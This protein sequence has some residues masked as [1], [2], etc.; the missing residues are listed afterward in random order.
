MFTEPPRLALTNSASTHNCPPEP[1]FTKPENIWQAR[2]EEMATIVVAEA[3]ERPK[4]LSYI[5]CHRE[6]R[7]ELLLKA[8]VE[9]EWETA[10]LLEF[11]EA[12]MALAKEGSLPGPPFKHGGRA[13]FLKRCSAALKSSNPRAEGNV[14][15]L[16]AAKQDQTRKALV[17]APHMQPYD[18]CFNE[19]CLDKKPKWID[20]TVSIPTVEGQFEEGVRSQCA[21][22]DCPKWFGRKLS[23]NEPPCFDLLTYMVQFKELTARGKLLL[24]GLSVR[25]PDQKP[26]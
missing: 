6:K 4:C 5:R 15:K 1:D 14:S 2:A 22:C 18:G 17:E 8:R 21:Y 19:S 7:R 26:H 23:S 16:S 10:T 13:E 11:V 24:E 3:G 9:A 25:S 20:K 12:A